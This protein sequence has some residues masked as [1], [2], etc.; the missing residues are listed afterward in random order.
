MPRKWVTKSGMWGTPPSQSK[1]KDDAMGGDPKGEIL[2][3]IKHYLRE[4]FPESHVMELNETA[5]GSVILYGTGEPRYRLEVTERFL[6]SD[7]G[8][9]LLLHQVRKWNVDGHLRQAGTRLV[10]LTTA[11]VRIEP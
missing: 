9:E 8:A 4:H 10:S 2:E 5:T 11:G 3:G 6:N 1:R 7:D